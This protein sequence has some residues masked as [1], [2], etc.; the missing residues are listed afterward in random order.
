MQDGSRYVISDTALAT[1]TSALDR[2]IKLI[3]ETAD[4]LPA[5]QNKQQNAEGDICLLSHEAGFAKL[6]HG[7]SPGV[8]PS[9]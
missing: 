2:T 4:A 9:D 7:S 8:P 1:T 5:V 6:Q 3:L